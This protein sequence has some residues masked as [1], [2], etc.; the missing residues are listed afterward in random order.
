M[1]ILPLEA[2]GR[3]D[4]GDML[5][6]V[7]VEMLIFLSQV[8]MFGDN[9]PIISG[10]IEAETRIGGWDEGK[11]GG[12]EEGNELGP[13][14]PMGELGSSLI[15]AGRHLTVTNPVGSDKNHSDL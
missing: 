8:T 6:V 10:V 13:L 14:F 4:L 5:A 15:D 11:G 2:V 1:Q 3:L 7:A 12:R 9:L